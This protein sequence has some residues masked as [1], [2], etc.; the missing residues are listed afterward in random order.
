MYYLST[1]YPK[2]HVGLRIGL[3]TGMYSVAGVLPG[4]LAY[5]LLKLNSQSIRGWQVVFLF[6]GA[7]T[8][9]LGLITILILP[10]SLDSA[11]FF[12]HEERAHTVRRMEVDLA[13]TQ[14]EADIMNTSIARRDF[15]DVAKDWKKVLIVV[16]NVTTVLPVTAFTTFLPLIVQGMG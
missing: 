12:T 10:K 5:G 1:I 15:V 9:T 4:L 3:F 13:G 14:D 6:E 2:Y 11:W 8:V 7:A 16:C